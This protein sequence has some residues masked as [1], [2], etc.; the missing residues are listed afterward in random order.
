MKITRRF[1]M[2]GDQGSTL[3]S[4]RGIT[5][6]NRFSHDTDAFACGRIPAVIRRPPNRISGWRNTYSAVRGET[7]PI[8]ELGRH[9]SANDRLDAE[10][11]E[12]V[13]GQTASRPPPPR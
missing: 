5:R 1:E 6:F 9:E 7:D 10:H 13:R 2:F 3:V 8:D 11:G 12:E 4:R